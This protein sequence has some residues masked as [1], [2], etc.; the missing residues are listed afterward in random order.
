M[1]DHFK[2][3]V[4]EQLEQGSEEWHQLKAGRISSTSVGGIFTKGK[5][6][7]GLGAGLLTQ[8]DRVTAEIKT[9]ESQSS[10]YTNSNM[11]RGKIMEQEAIREYEIETFRVVK[12]IGFVA[13]GKYFGDSPDGWV[14]EDGCIE[15]KSPTAKVHQKYLRLSK[16]PKWKTEYHTQIKWHMFVGKKKWCDFISFNPDFPEKERLLVVRYTLTE[17]E[18]RLMTEKAKSLVVAIEENLP[19]EFKQAA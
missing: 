5:D 14:G 11:E 4:H 17:E 1:I 19:S 6:K 2:I 15:A 18:I 7:W 13:M 16:D 12:S 8:L 9:G 10:D 3:T